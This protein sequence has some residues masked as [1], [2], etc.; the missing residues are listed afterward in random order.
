[1]KSD[2][3]S[4]GCVLY[5]LMTGINLKEDSIEALQKMKEFIQQARQ[6]MYQGERRMGPFSDQCF[7]LLQWML[8]RAAKQRPSALD[9]LRHPWFASHQGDI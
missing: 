1:M 2:I 7:D 6:K 4:L 8:S 9:S 5:S 3:F